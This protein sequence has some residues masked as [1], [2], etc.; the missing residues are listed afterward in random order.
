[1]MDRLKIESALGNAASVLGLAI[2]DG[3]ENWYAQAS[4]ELEFDDK[5]KDKAGFRAKVDWLV[6]WHHWPRPYAMA[7]WY[8]LVTETPDPDRALGDLAELAAPQ[9][10]WLR[11]RCAE[12]VPAALI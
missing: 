4:V 8:V 5:I 7:I 9:I 10:A 12:L 11:E 1:M 3:L 2:T 6:T